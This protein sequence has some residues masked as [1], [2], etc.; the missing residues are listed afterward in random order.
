MEVGP[1]CSFMARTLGV[2]QEAHSPAGQGGDRCR[3]QLHR[4]VWVEKRGEQ[5]PMDTGT[6]PGVRHGR[7]EQ[8]AVG[9]ARFQCDPWAALD[10]RG[11]ESAPYEL[12]RCGDAGQPCADHD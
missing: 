3:T 7:C 11:L 10:Y 12:V 6:V 2:A 1:G 4:R 9:E 8:A 5:L